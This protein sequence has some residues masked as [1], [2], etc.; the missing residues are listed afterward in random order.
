MSLHCD[1]IKTNITLYLN[2]KVIKIYELK[3]SLT[4]FYNSFARLF[5][6]N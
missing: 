2:Q 1:G 3:K 6:F 4:P 5:S